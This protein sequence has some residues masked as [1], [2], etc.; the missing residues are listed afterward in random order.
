M[1][2]WIVACAVLMVVGGCSVGTERGD[3]YTD[4]HA[5]SFPSLS[6][7]GLAKL[8]QGRILLRHIGES[9]QSP[10]WF[11]SFAAGD[12]YAI[13]FDCTGVLGKASIKTDSSSMSH[14][15]SKGPNKVRFSNGPG[16][17]RIRRLDVS[18]PEGASW[19]IV[20]FESPTNAD[21][22]RP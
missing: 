5:T 21:P 18:V 8:A 9:R 15:C 22:A 3:E 16:G 1:H 7:D 2:R 14:Q 13:A 17:K 4:G 11:G 19:A 10:R 20:I 6:P 12:S